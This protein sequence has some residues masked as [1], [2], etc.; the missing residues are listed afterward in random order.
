MRNQPVT[1][2]ISDDSSETVGNVSGLRSI[3]LRISHLKT[4]I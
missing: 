4:K 1:L 2:I 3:C